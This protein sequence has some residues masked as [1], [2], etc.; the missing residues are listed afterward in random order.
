MS[1]VEIVFFSFLTILA[2]PFFAGVYLMF[3]E[4]MHEFFESIRLRKIAKKLS[5][6]DKGKVESV[7][8]VVN[9]QDVAY[10]EVHAFCH[11]QLRIG[12]SKGESVKWCAKCEC[13]IERENDGGDGGGGGKKPPSPVDPN[14]SWEVIEEANSLLKKLTKQ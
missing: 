11:K 1:G 12:L 14:P 2:I 6:I 9:G 5:L 4:E 13:I 8:K 10:N 3:R 7:R